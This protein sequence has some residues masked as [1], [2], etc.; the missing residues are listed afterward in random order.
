MPRQAN[1]RHN[2][3]AENLL[4]AYIDYNAMDVDQGDAMDVDDT[5]T[6]ADEEIPQ[7]C[8]CGNINFFRGDPDLR[9]LWAAAQTELLTYRRLR[10]GDRWV[11]RNF[12]QEELL[13]N[14]EARHGVRVGLVESEMMQEYCGCGRFQYAIDEDC[15]CEDEACAYFFRIWRRSGSG[16]L[17]SCP[18][19][20]IGIIMSRRIIRVT[21]KKARATRVMIMILFRRARFLNIS[22]QREQGHSSHVI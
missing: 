5:N 17:S 13:E 12:M 22:D 21:K 9:D 18:R 16:R 6:S 11:S 15:V 2:S 3:P 20:R 7:R 4:T 8:E 1:P 10:D 19:R 14:I